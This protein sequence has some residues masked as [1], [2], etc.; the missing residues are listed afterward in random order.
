MAFRIAPRPIPSGQLRAGLQLSY[1]GL[2]SPQG[3]EDLARLVLA[4]GLHEARRDGGCEH[5]EEAD[6]DEHEH[7]ADEPTDDG[8]RVE[9][10]VADRRDGD[11]SPPDAVPERLELALIDGGLQRRRR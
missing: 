10:A 11:D 5:S 9:V 6:A 2:E 1:V 3:F 4:V 8:R 7:D